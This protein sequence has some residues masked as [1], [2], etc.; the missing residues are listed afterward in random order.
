MRPIGH[1]SSAFKQRLQGQSHQKSRGNG[2]DRRSQGSQPP[3]EEL[4]EIQ[5]QILAQGRQET[6][7]GKRLTDQIMLSKLVGELNPMHAR[8]AHLIRHLTRTD[9]YQMLLDLR[10]LLGPTPSKR[11]NQ[12]A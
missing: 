4:S 8:T 12:D 3:R 6:K 7:P 2:E 9:F 1:F 5:A 11:D 10:M